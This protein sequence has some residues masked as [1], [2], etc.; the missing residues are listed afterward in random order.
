MLR[1]SATHVEPWLTASPSVRAK[2]KKRGAHA[3]RVEPI[4]QLKPEKLANKKLLAFTKQKQLGAK[5]A[6]K[7]APTSAIA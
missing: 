1:K 4:A 7:A 6:H 5:N 2:P 3:W